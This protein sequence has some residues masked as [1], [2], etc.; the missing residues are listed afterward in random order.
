MHWCKSL[1]TD[2]L[3]ES[4]MGSRWEMEMIYFMHLYKNFGLVDYMIQNI[5]SFSMNTGCH[6]YFSSLWWQRL[7]IRTLKFNVSSKRAWIYVKSQGRLN[8]YSYDGRVC[9]V[10]HAYGYGTSILIPG[11]C[12]EPIE[13][14]W[15]VS[16]VSHSTFFPSIFPVTVGEAP[17]RTEC[18]ACNNSDS[19][20]R[21][22]NVGANQLF[23]AS[24]LQFIN[25][26]LFRTE[27]AGQG[28]SSQYLAHGPDQTF[29]KSLYL[30]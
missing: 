17:D 9:C 23:L 20:K 14:F 16:V 28:T 5:Q 10:V 3:T 25:I 7:R 6:I 21:K 22:K 19:Q 8:S 27:K 30:Q 29:A 15:I 4:N 11:F 2:I 1:S 18:K 26:Q 13:H 12:D 24:R